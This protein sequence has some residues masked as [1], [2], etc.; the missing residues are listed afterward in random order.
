MEESELRDAQKE[1]EMRKKAVLRL[2]KGRKTRSD[3]EMSEEK[4]AAILQDEI[5]RRL[6]AHKEN[7]AKERVERL[8]DEKRV[9]ASATAEAAS[10]ARHAQL[11]H[12]SVE[13]G[14]DSE[15]VHGVVVAEGKDVRGA[16]LVGDVET[17]P[18]RDSSGSGSDSSTS[19][20]SSDSSDPDSTNSSSEALSADSEEGLVLTWDVNMNTMST[21]PESA[22]ELVEL[23]SDLREKFRKEILHEKLISELQAGTHK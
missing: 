20:T 4:D 19:K 15:N 17:A 1:E 23:D 12:V 21:A 3:R 18:Q 6:F 2:Q 5:E 14:T 13:Q 8:E 16:L 11:T 9:R 22:S 10:L 7:R